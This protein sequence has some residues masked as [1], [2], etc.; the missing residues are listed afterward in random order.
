MD[1]L[2]DENSVVEGLDRQ[3]FWTFWKMSRHGHAVHRKRCGIRT[4]CLFVALGDATNIGL[5]EFHSLSKG[6][7]LS[8]VGSY[9]RIDCP[10]KASTFRSGKAETLNV[11]QVFHRS[12]RCTNGVYL[13]ALSRPATRASGP[14]MKSRMSVGNYSGASQLPIRNPSYKR[15][16]YQCSQNC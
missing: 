13:N 8:R 11:L 14:S 6:F 5:E 7:P 10:F 1:T 4:R 3:D 9:T 2:F 12:I 16:S 15:A